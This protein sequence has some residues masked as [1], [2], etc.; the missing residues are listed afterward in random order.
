[1]TKFRKSPAA[2]KNVER[3]VRARDALE[4][5]IKGLSLE[6][7]AARLGMKSKSGVHKLIHAELREIAEERKALGNLTLDLE[8]ERLDRLERA[9]AKKVD[10]GDVRSI[11][12]SLKII[13][14]RAKLLGLDS[15]ERHQHEIDTPSRETAAAI[16]REVFGS[17]SAL[18]HKPDGE[19]PE[20]AGAVEGD[21]LSVPAP[22]DQ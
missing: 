10:E 5:R 16:A 8:L 15:P 9:I 3:A 11:E 12:A 7:V 22:M 14:R 21:V 2:P 20:S 18:E 1:M 17:P 6:E 4:L 19:H 13:E